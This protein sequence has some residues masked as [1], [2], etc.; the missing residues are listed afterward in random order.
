[1]NREEEVKKKREMLEQTYYVS[2]RYVGL[3]AAL[4]LYA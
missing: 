3:M 2:L 1:M 4:A